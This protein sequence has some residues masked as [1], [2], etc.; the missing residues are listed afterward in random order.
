MEL[1]NYDVLAKSGYEGYV[2]KEAPVRVLQFG[3]GNFMRAFVDYFFDISNEKAGFNGKV[4]LVQPISMGLT[5]LINKQEGLYTLYLRGSENGEKVDA[6]R[7]ISAVDCCLNPY[8]KAD[9]DKM[10]EIAVSDDLDIIASNTTEA[11]IAYDPSCNFEDVPAN[12]FPGKLTQVLFARYKAGKKGVVV[13]S[14]ELIDNNGKELLKC[15]NQY[16]D[17]WKLEDGFK[18]WVNEENIFCST[19]VD[20]IV[21]G[22]IRDAKEVEQLEAANGYHDELIDVG[23]IFGVWIIEGP[24]GLEDRLPFKKA[25]VNVHVVP[26]VMPYKH[27]KVRILNGAHTGFVLGAYLAGFDIVRDCMHNDN[28]AGFMNKMLNEEVI[29]TL[30]DH[31]DEN[32]LN[33]FAA[34]VKDRFNNPFVNHELMSISLNSTSKWKARNMPSFLQY[35][36]KNG[37]L[38]VCLTMSLAAYIAFYSNDVQELT[39]AG[40]VCKRPAGNTYTVSDDRWA[41]EFFYDHKNDSEEE[42]VKAVL[43]NEKM[44]NQDLNKIDGLTDAVVADLKKIHSEGAEAAYASCL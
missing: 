42:L 35:I 22:R 38:P 30:V 16:I 28:V 43:G 24:E 27:R 13:L 37:K 29:P 14:C 11:G 31:L 17:Q 9:Y 12:S 40:L 1:L 26:D 34:A 25:G 20:R 41:L 7:V 19:L 15:V 18:T 32:D 33:E 2:C 5:E 10:M 36:D 44:W 3:E 39:D 8:D 23:E 6:K 21:P 4:A